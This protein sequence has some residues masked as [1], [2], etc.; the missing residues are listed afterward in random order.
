MKPWKQMTISSGIIFNFRLGRFANK[1]A[2]ANHD[3]TAV[4][5]VENFSPPTNLKKQTRGQCYKTFYVRNLHIFV[6]S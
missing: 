2:S 1:E 5:K 4:S 3:N 6:I